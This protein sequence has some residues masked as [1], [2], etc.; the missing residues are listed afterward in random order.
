MGG[1]QPRRQHLVIFAQPA[2]VFDPQHPLLGDFLVAR[3]GGE[4][5]GDQLLGLG[6][7]PGPRK[8]KPCQPRGQ[9]RQGPAQDGRGHEETVEHG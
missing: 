8:I 4:I 2:P 7:A 5:P 9:R 1:P 6:A 3:V